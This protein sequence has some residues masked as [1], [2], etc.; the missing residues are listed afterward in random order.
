MTVRNLE[1]R[2]RRNRVNFGLEC[3]IEKEL[4]PRAKRRATCEVQ[5]SVDIG[6]GDF[7]PPIVSCGLNQVVCLHLGSIRMA[8]LHMYVLMFRPV[9]EPANFREPR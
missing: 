6:S 2:E 8:S 1:R 4:E 3:V 9:G 7:L 5:F